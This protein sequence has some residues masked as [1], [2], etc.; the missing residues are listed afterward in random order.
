MKISAGPVI[1]A[2]PERSAQLMNKSKD[3]DY[4][5]K[6][7]LSEGESKVE[8]CP[9]LI[10][11][12]KG[13][14]NL[15]KERN[16]TD[17]SKTKT[18]KGIRLGK[19][20]VYCSMALVLTLSFVFVQP[21]RVAGKES[22]EKIKSMVYEVIKGK[23]GKYVAVKV[24][25]REPQKA[26]GNIYEGTKKPIEQDLISKVP[27]S[28]AGG[29]TLDHQALGYY[30]SK[31]AS[32]VMVSSQNGITKELYDKFN[33]TLSSFYIKD[34]S[35]IVLEISY[36]DFPFALNNRKER[37]EG[38]NKKVISFGDVTATYAE[39]PGI[40]YPISQNDGNEDRTQEPTITVL[41]TIKWKHNEVYYTVYDFNGDLSL[42][43]LEAAA[44]TI[45]ERMN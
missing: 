11:E 17:M 16:V 2:A 35:K 33:E 12:V 43:E 13:K 10:S 38:D 21:F 18:L 37:I 42:E 34:G 7:A 22:I 8:L 24:P 6:K 39:Y 19:T 40:R 32:M 20:A 1:P 28:L 14:L 45:I 26:D 25:Y 36:M 23:D 44:A 27:E 15:Q 9:N 3:I 29:Y 4:L 31:S 41:H 5:I 30:D